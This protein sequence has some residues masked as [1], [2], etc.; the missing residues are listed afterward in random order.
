M[1]RTTVVPLRRIGIVGQPC[2]QLVS[3][4]CFQ[5]D[6]YGRQDEEDE[7]NNDFSLISMIILRSLQCWPL[8]LVF[9]PSYLPPCCFQLSRTYSYTLTYPTVLT[10]VHCDGTYILSSTLCRKGLLGYKMGG[11]SGLE[12]QQAAI[13]LC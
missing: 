2:S 6:S 13:C 11:S 7:D 3:Y 4:G 12:R 5:E 9:L 8:L 10:I 1:V